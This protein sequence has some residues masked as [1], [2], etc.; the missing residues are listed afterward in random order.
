MLDGTW[1]Q[2]KALWWRNSWLLKLKRIVL[3]P[4]LPSQYGNLRKEPRKEAVSTME[5]VALA[6][7]ELEPQGDAVK[8]YLND[9]FAQMLQQYRENKRK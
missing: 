6:L 9:T 3:Q 1:S 5:S 2:V 7:G 8:K 4:Q